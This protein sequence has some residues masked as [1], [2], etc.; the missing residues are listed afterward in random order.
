MKNKEIPSCNHFCLCKTVKTT[1]VEVWIWTTHEIPYRTRHYLIGQRIYIRYGFIGGGVL[2][3]YPCFLMILQ[4]APFSTPYIASTHSA[5]Q[6]LFKVVLIFWWNIQ[7]FSLLYKTFDMHG[8]LVSKLRSHPVAS[9]HNIST[10]PQLVSVAIHLMSAR[11]V[12]GIQS[13]TV[14]PVGISHFPTLNLTNLEQLRIPA[15]HL[16]WCTKNYIPRPLG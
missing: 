3:V 7:T 1:N 14:L 15:W 9:H 5:T 12:Q 6:H 11:T 4:H 2:S 13:N 16:C 8:L 10:T